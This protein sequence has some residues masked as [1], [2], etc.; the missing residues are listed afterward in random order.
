MNCLE[1]GQIQAFLDGELSQL[2]VENVSMHLAECD[3]CGIALAD[4]EEEN[5]IVFSTLAREMDSL[6]PSQRLWAKINSGIEAERSVSGRWSNFISELKRA[7]LR[8]S[9]A[10]AA[11]MVLMI[12]GFSWIFISGSKNGQQTAATVASPAFTID[13]PKISQV[14]AATPQTETSFAAV[15]AATVS[16]PPVVTDRSNIAVRRPSNDYDATRTAAASTAIPGEAMYVKTIATLGRSGE[17]GNVMRASERIAYERDM[18]IV[19]DSI[20]RLRSEV[21]R[22]PANQAARQMLYTS[23]QNKIDLLNSAAQQADAIASLH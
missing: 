15:R 17:A 19:D 6:V 1:T 9:M 2:E 18:A 12:A 20:K 11:V 13:Q 14:E 16:R 5:S 23:Y 21:K 10:A 3:A 22:H 7:F 8:P 4:A